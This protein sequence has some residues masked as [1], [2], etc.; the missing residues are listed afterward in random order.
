MNRL[1]WLIGAAVLAALAALAAAGT[2]T[3]V[4]P[5]GSTG[6]SLA[7]A[8]VATASP[9]HGHTSWHKVASLSGRDLKY[10]KSFTVAGSD[11]QLVIS[12]RGERW[13]VGAVGVMD[14]H[15]SNDTE[16]HASLLVNGGGRTS[17]PLHLRPGRYYLSGF[18]ESQWTAVLLEKR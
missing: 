9:V 2:S 12:M 16:T 14:R 1:K 17:S 8:V 11:Q 10:G 7:G 15:R 4:P 13:Q 6:S 5:S 18:G 3:A